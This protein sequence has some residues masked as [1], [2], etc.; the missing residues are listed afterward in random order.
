MGSQGEEERGRDRREGRAEEEKDLV[1]IWACA[2]SWSLGRTEG[3][4][5]PPG[6][7]LPQ[8]YSAPVSP[9]TLSCRT[10]EGQ[11]VI[12]ERER[13]DQVICRYICL[14]TRSQNAHV[15]SAEHLAEYG[16]T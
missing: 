12:L 15:A 2:G 16:I 8:S 14:S 3:L 7:S 6:P 4:L 11:A 1:W 13:Q 5:T 9:E 10:E